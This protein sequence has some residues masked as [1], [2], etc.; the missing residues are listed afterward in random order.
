MANENDAEVRL[1]ANTDELTD[2]M[3]EASASVETSLGKMSKELVSMS[4]IMGAVSGVVSSLTTQLTDRLTSA[5]KDA[6]Q[7]FSTLSKE[8]EGF[9]N[10]TGTSLRESSIMVD[11]LQD[12]GL[13]TQSY[14][15][16]V[17]RVSRSIRT[18]EEAFTRMGI[19]IRD[20]K[21]EL[22]PM[23]EVVRNSLAA[24]SQYKEGTDRNAA[25]M[26][27]LRM[28][29]KELAPLQRVTEDLMNSNAEA[30]DNFGSIITNNDVEA[31][32]SLKLA[33][34]D[35]L[36]PLEAM[37][38]VIGRALNPVLTDLAGILQG[39]LTGAFYIITGAIRGLLTFFELLLNGIYTITEPLVGAG[40]S[41]MIFLEGIGDA[42]GYLG[43]G[44]LD[45]ARASM[46]MTFS[47]MEANSKQTLQ[48]IVDHN[49][50]A[51]ARIA[52]MWNVGDKSDRA[53]TGDKNYS[54]KATGSDDPLKEWKK[55]L[56]E[57]R[58]AAELFHELSKGDEARMWEAKLALTK[59]GSDEYKA[60]FHLLHQA[61][62]AQGNEQLAELRKTFAFEQALAKDNAARRME[63]AQAERDTIVALH[64]EESAK[65]IEAERK[66]TLFKQAEAEKR[67]KL[68]EEAIGFR[69]EMSRIQADVEEENISF[70]KSLNLLTEEEK[71]NA[72]ILQK[73]RAYEIERQHM[74]DK[75]KLYEKDTVEYQKSLDDMAK[76]E[77]KHNLDVIKLQHQKQLESVRIWGDLF[78]GIANSFKNVA[79]GLAM[80]TMTMRKAT[81]ALLNGIAGEFLSM[82]FKIVADWMKRQIMMTLFGEVQ[83]GER[84][85]TAVAEAGLVAA[86][87]GAANQALI[88][89][90]AGV[91]GAAG[92][93]S[94]AA[95]P[96]YGWAMAPEAGMLDYAAAM[97]FSGMS[98]LSAA[99][100]AWDIPEDQ[101]AM[102]HK[103]ESILPADIAEPLRESVEGGTLGGG[104]DHYTI[105]ALDTRGLET[106]LKR[107]STSLGPALRRVTRNGVP[108]ST[109]K[110][111]LGKVF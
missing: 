69:Q 94:A 60:V 78:D 103:K 54:P 3:K 21:G 91:A 15:S 59:R 96:Y 36:K 14:E 100:G 77:A 48:N 90:Y 97:A 106:W 83:A 105:Q 76:A 9:S 51:V 22:L 71:I 98:M 93:S 42:L 92:V 7:Q 33:I 44:Q 39:A 11:S 25:S 66:L 111:P 108:S 4:G 50:A 67:R 65:G 23:T 41:I 31:M 81:T 55:E 101:M 26:E 75:S 35:A 38:V 45:M 17:T 53:K 43:S 16:L 1:G 63:V 88:S 85:A 74:Q 47:A 27:L 34:A 87:Q 32:W 102:V 40:R 110:T 82:G 79:M 2:K 68:E 24:L 5:V 61:R 28:G 10:A 29:W 30:A 20:A 13:S 57:M 12:L 56:E 8:I 95:I 62:V 84:V 73:Q 89:S 52:T 37:G 72:M 6:A 64:G 107:N 18:K 58:D 46:K 86:A 70:L 99:G 104:G 19:S 109:T 49:A 80:G